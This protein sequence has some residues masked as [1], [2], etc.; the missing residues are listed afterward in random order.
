MHRAA[1]VLVSQ[2]CQ[3]G[4]QRAAALLEPLAHLTK[5]AGVGVAVE[6]VLA[7]LPV[8]Q[9]AEATLPQSSRTGEAVARGR[10]AGR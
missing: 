3:G 10:G 6:G 5:E 2:L 7:A 4:L 8:N 9:N 1:A